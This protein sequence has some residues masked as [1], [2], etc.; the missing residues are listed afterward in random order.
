MSE[1]S[2]RKSI[3]NLNLLD[4]FLFLAATTD[5]DNAKLI[6]RVIIRRVFGWNLTD[7]EV[8]AERQYPGVNVGQKGIRL[9]LEVIEKEDGK[10]VR[11]V[12]LLNK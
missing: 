11:S 10:V 6:A 12:K 5:P 2:C 4:S 8:G 9:D 1:N 3:E 7:I